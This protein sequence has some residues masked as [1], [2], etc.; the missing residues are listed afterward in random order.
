MPTT[1]RLLAV[2]LM[3]FPG[4]TRSAAASDTP[5]PPDAVQAAAE[6]DAVVIRGY[7]RHGE[8][9]ERLREAHARVVPAE[10]SRSADLP[11]DV[12]ALCLADGSCDLVV[13][14]RP[15]LAAERQR[16]NF[17]R[18][19][20]LL[21][22]PIALDAAVFLAHPDTPLSALTLDQV[23]G[24]VNFRIK[25]WKDLG[26]QIDPKVPEQ[27]CAICRML[28]E[29][30]EGGVAHAH[31][32]HEYEIVPP[33]LNAS[34]GS[35]EALRLLLIPTQALQPFAREVATS[36]AVWE[37]VRGDPLA[38]GWAA[39]DAPAEARVLP[40]RRDESSPPVRPTP[41]N[42]RDRSYPL[43]H[44]VYLVTTNPPSSEADRFIRFATS[45]EGQR[46]VRQAELGFVPLFYVPV[47]VTPGAGS[48]AEQ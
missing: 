14:G 12:G 35:P 8:L 26:I 18:K 32:D 28:A 30:G 29:R 11:A 5:A 27:L 33:R 24:I 41:G 6:T 45:I 25:R 4:V 22:V 34:T 38:I 13:L 21:V 20:D 36:E 2:C 42:V 9:A 31:H 37:I 19:T 47:D 15:P 23:R 1:H 10:P 17:V 43:A 39:L 40:L 46:A 7:R 44:Y 48:A 16:I 3:L